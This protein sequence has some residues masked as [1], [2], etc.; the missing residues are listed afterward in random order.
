MK[1]VAAVILIAAVAVP[2]YHVYHANGDSFDFS[3]TETKVVVSGSMD[4][5]PRSEYDIPT[6]PIGSM[7]FIQKP[8]SEEFYESLS[9]GDVLTFHYTDPV[10][11]KDMVVTHRIVGITYTGYDYKYVLA[12][13]AVADDPFNTA[14]QTVYSS[15]GDI[16]GKVVGVSE[17]LGSVATFVSSAAGKAVLIGLFAAII[18]A[19]WVAPAIL[20][21]LSK[22][23]KR[24]D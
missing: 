15:S 11:R 23:E 17:T 7:V 18:A 19:I 9:V 13:D 16:V 3:N 22:A 5:T 1:L 20:R 2:C 10:S 8:V 21:L 14:T 12:G 6:I 24:C 4:G